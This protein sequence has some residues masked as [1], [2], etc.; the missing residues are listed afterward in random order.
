MDNYGASM[1]I[2]QRL[3]TAREVND[4]NEVCRSCTEIMIDFGSWHRL[5]DLILSI[6]H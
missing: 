1:L 3:T 5:L 2:A 6:S 4:E